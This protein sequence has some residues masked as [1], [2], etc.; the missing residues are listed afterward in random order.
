MERKMVPLTDFIQDNRF[1]LN[2]YLTY[3][4]NEAKKFPP[5]NKLDFFV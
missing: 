2:S 5:G 1:E 3:I 4:F